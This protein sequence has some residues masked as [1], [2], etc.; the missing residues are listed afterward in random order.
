MECYQYLVG[1]INVQFVMIYNLCEYCELLHEKTHNVKIKKAS[2][3]LKYDLIAP[4][5]GTKYREILDSI[6]PSDNKYKYEIMSEHMQINFAKENIGIAFVLKEDV[7]K[8]IDAGELV[9]IDIKNSPK[10]SVGIGVLDKKMMNFA[11]KEFLKYIK[12]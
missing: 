2:D 10:I 11:T 6:L 1:D 8:E 5:K 7:Q 9:Q 4:R 3:I 12:Q